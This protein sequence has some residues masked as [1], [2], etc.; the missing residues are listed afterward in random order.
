MNNK[1]TCQKSTLENNNE[2]FFFNENEKLYVKKE[3][4]KNIFFLSKKLRRPNT[5][6]INKI[7]ISN[8]ILPKVPD[9]CKLNLSEL[10][11]KNKTFKKNNL[12]KI[13]NS[14]SI[15][16][17]KSIS[18][19]DKLNNSNKYKDINTKEK[20]NIKERIFLI[21][22]NSNI[23]SNEI[24]VKKNNKLIFMNKCLIKP[25]KKN[26][27]IIKKPLRKSL[28]RGVSKNGKNWQTIVSS[29]YF[30]GYI[31]TYPTEE[32]A[33]RV[34]DVVSIKNWGIKAKTNFQYNLH[35]I[36][37]INEAIIDFNAKNIEEIISNLI[38]YI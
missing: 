31:G 37:R 14:N 10:D 21:Y 33:A 3:N 19:K 23:I 27:N 1:K 36:Q 38:N 32:L 28:Y 7:D 35:Q 11:I 17:D 13:E 2:N 5:Y 20:K 22:K 34:Y 6:Y 30:K 16:I 8:K 29:K 18:K 25:K 24:R 4:Y 15:S 26:K 9:E 12:Y